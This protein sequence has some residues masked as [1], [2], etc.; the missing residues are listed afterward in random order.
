MNFA[1]RRGRPSAKQVAAIDEAIL[2]TARRM[3]LEEGFDALAMDA[4]IA[5][6]GISKG[7]LY[8]RHPSKE[9]LLSA[10]IKDSI[11]DWSSTS[12]KSDHLLP[13]ELGDRLRERLRSIGRGLTNPEVECYYRLLASVRHRIPEV[14]LIF[15]D[16]GYQRGVEVIAED[17]RA[18]A[19]RDGI[20]ASD[21][22]G[23]AGLLLSAVCGWHQQ[24][25]GIRSPSPTE[26][27][28]VAD[29]AVAVFM[30]SREIW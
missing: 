15:Y 27:E 25:S 17:I 24:E 21:P 16:L 22:D 8:S 30:M 9:A 26:M 14:S 1:P 5:E 19:G 23:I 7:T 18:A 28:Q 10:V 11:E 12:S 13:T 20:P 29:R 3:F 4:V 2:V 6:L